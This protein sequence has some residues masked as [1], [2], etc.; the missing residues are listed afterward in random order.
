MIPAYW[1]YPVAVFSACFGF[2]M[3]VYYGMKGREK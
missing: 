2:A 3:G 1:L